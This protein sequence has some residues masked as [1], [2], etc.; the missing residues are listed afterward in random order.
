MNEREYEEY[1][2][3][4]R[5]ESRKFK[6]TVDKIRNLYVGDTVAWDEA[7]RPMGFFVDGYPERHVS[8]LDPIRKV[9]ESRRGYFSG[10]IDERTLKGRMREIANHLTDEEL[11][12][13]EP[14]FVLIRDLFFHKDG[15]TRR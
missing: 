8:V 13:C 7:Q 10:K 6:N 1:I 2:A 12:L 4:I 9:F 15:F 14:P 11:D 3:H 5:T